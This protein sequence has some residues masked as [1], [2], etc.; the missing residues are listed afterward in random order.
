MLRDE[1]DMTRTHPHHPSVH[2]PASVSA[3]VSLL[4]CFAQHHPPSHAKNH[5]AFPQPTRSCLARGE[6]R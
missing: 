5:M 3:V 2:R 1:S 6:S 4:G